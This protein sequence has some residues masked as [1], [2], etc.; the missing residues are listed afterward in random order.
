MLE[1][2][3]KYLIRY[4][5]RY[6]FLFIA[7]GFGFFLITFITSIKDGMTE[8]VYLTAQSHYAG[9]VIVTAYDADIRKLSRIKGSDAEIVVQAIDA[10]QLNPERV[11][12]RT[13]SFE[14]GTVYFNGMGIP[15]KYVIGVDWENEREY[16]ENITY[17]DAPIN[18]SDI[19]ENT[20][21]LSS[22]VAEKGFV[23][24][25]VLFLISRLQ[26]DIRI[27][28]FLSFRPSLKINRFSVITRLLSQEMC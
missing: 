18:F 23:P 8:N 6:L 24:E 20:M 22:P 28:V 27:P 7:M 5:R 10:S 13:M 21:V 15:L 3:V 1:L 2:A 9:D 16:F 17:Q 4:R 26:K 19:D 25:T 11:V 12:Y 14:R